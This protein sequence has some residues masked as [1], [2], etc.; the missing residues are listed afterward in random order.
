MATDFYDTGEIYYVV[1]SIKKKISATNVF[2][3]F[4]ES[5]KLKQKFFYN[6]CDNKIFLQ[7]SGGNIVKLIVNESAI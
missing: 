6:C 3:W 4:K 1:K 2:I 5:Y 7:V